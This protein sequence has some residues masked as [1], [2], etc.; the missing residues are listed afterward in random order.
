MDNLTEKTLESKILF[1]GKILTLRFDTV[2]LP[3]GRQATREVIEH[4]GAVA[5]VPI[6]DDGRIIL[7]RQ[8]R[9]PLGELML[10]IP[11]GKLDKGESPDDCVRR[12]LAEET[13]YIGR[14]IRKITSIH[15]TPGFSNELI[16]IYIARDLVP[17]D[18]NLDEDEFIN[19]EYYTKDEIKSMLDNGVFSDAKTM[20]GLLLAGI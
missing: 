10:E 14:N 3:N 19:V 11:A 17:T 13:G 18:Q 8:Y 6:M 2:S 4:P 20:V 12:E 15:T 1:A 16:H 5:V 9:H 7:V